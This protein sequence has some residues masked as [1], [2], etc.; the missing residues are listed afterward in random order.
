MID[1][2]KNVFMHVKGKKTEPLDRK[3][4]TAFNNVFGDNDYAFSTVFE[5][6]T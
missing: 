2:L 5:F 4:I 3:T 1:I 6:K